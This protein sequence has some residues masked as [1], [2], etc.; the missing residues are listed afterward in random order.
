M[1]SLGGYLGYIGVASS[2]TK[3]LQFYQLATKNVYFSIFLI[4]K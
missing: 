4:Q 2:T 3:V 1:G